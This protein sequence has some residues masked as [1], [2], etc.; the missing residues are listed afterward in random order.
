MLGAFDCGGAQAGCPGDGG[1]R[2]GAVSDRLGSGPQSQLA[3]AEVR[4]E[5]SV[6]LR[7]LALVDHCCDVRAY[8]AGASVAAG[9]AA[10]AA[11]GWGRGRIV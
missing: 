11:G 5:K 8:R 2:S 1:Y 6:A 3:V 10:S 4:S 9:S 7:D